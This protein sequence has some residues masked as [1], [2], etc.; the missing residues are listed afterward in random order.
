MRF[1]WLSLYIIAFRWNFANVLALCYLIAPLGFCEPLS[2]VL[3][4]RESY[5]CGLLLFLPYLLSTEK[6]LQNNQIL[7]I[8]KWHSLQGI[9]TKLVLLSRCY[10]CAFAISF[11]VTTTKVLLFIVKCKLFQAFPSCWETRSSFSLLEEYKHYPFPCASHSK[12]CTHKNLEWGSTLRNCI[13]YM[14]FAKH[15]VHLA[16]CLKYLTCLSHYLIAKMK[17]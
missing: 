15:I 9:T 16:Q 5:W 3:D 10:K 17:I 1:H 13:P 12:A 8:K 14:T 7:I 2:K 6:D 4:W 11:V